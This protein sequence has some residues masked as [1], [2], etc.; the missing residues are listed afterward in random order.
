MLQ[1]E[2][3]IERSQTISLQDFARKCKQRIIA[4]NKQNKEMAA[5]CN[6]IGAKH[7]ELLH[8]HDLLKLGKLMPSTTTGS[9]TFTPLGRTKLSRI[10]LA[11]PIMEEDEGQE[12]EKV[13][14]PMSSAITPP[15]E[16]V[17]SWYVLINN[18]FQ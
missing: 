18:H 14:E 10:P 2:L 15:K 17:E 6:S 7:R 13:V 4:L 1:N 16:Q 5:A 8:A 12:E 11:E 9:E 3:T